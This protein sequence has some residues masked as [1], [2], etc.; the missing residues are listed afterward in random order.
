MRVRNL[1]LYG[2]FDHLFDRLHIVLH[3]LQLRLLR[4]RLGVA[5]RDNRRCGSE[6]GGRSGG[7]VGQKVLAVGVVTQEISRDLIFQK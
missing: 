4:L 6:G 3:H 7:R 1:L 5:A 2:L